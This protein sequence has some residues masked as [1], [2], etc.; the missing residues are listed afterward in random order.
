MGMSLLTL[1]FVSG[2]PVTH[3]TICH[4]HRLLAH[5]CILV[6][7]MAALQVFQKLQ[8]MTTMTILSGLPQVQYF[9]DPL[10]DSDASWRCMSH[11]RHHLLFLGRAP[12]A[13]I[14]CS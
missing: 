12:F 4:T 8:T 14:V 7:H 11:I 5:S 1:Q 13:V 2:C 6:I 10:F 9:S 3:G